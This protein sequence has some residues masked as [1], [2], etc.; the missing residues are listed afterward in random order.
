M[1]DDLPTVLELL[2]ESG[3]RWQTLRAEGEEWADPEASRAAFTRAA[4]PGSVFTLRGTP[5][6]SDHDPTWKVWLRR[7]DRSR[8]DFGGAH[9]TRFLV[10]TDGDRV[11]TSH[12][13]GGYSIRES[14]PG[15]HEIL[16]GPAGALLRPSSLPAILDLEVVGRR[17]FLGRDVL[18]VRGRPRADVDPHMALSTRGAD[19][20]EL[21]V[22]VERGVLLWL[23]SRFAGVP[24]R[25][26]AMTE[27]AFDEDLDDDL[28]AFPEGPDTPPPVPPM[29]GRPPS[30]TQFGPP[31]GVL[32][33]PVPISAVIVRTASL[34]IAVQRVTAYPT[35]LELEI[36]VRV[37]TEPVHGS[38]DRIQ[39]RTWGGTS[40]FPGEAL[41][42]GVV[43]PDGRRAWSENFGTGPPPSGDVTL[44]PIGGSGT[45]A[46]FDQRF[47]VAPLPPPGPLGVVVEWE[48]R[49]LPETRVDLDAAAIVDAADGAESLWE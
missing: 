4:R 15:P 30:R 20:V 18:T 3:R 38:F 6:P 46:R 13:R 48:S 29:P 42:V 33:R 40:A 2:H 37:R 34:V 7:P 17:T 22:D 1:A 49:D 9:Q 36:T 32:G 31:D 8:V 11:C 26:T 21:G 44:L 23:E 19:E 35:G 39:R 24:F 45:Q 27:V 10:I 14:R 28:F 12:P 43:F 47:W 16:L 41:R 5:G 25:R